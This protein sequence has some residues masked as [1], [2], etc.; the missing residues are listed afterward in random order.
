[1]EEPGPPTT[2]ELAQAI[3]AQ[4]GSGRFKNT[5]ALGDVKG[6][7]ESLRNALQS[8]C[9]TDSNTF[10]VHVI[11]QLGRTRYHL[12]SGLYRNLNYQVKNLG[13]VSGG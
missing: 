11:A 9:V 4:R 8:L 13:V 7:D 2:P 12:V 5:S 1:M 6:L 3:I 10:S